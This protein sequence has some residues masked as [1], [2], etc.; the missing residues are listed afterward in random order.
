MPI[1]LHEILVTGASGF[2]GTRLIQLLQA[3]GHR[4][5][6]LDLVPG[7][8]TDIIADV[9]DR[10]ALEAH[11]PEG[12]IVF[13]LAS[14]VG[15]VE[16]LKRPEECYSCSVEGTR[17]LCRSAEKRGAR[18]V[19]T[20][21]SE[22]YGDGAGEL[23]SEDSSLPA[24][25]GPWPRASY[26][27]GKLRAE[28]LVRTFH[29]RGGDGRIARFFNVTGPGQEW[30]KGP[31]LPTFVHHA[32]HGIPL[33]VIGEGGDVRC[34]QHVDD[35][36]AGLMK[37]GLGDGLAGQTINLGGMD[38]VSVE[39]LAHR[40]LSLLNLS[41]TIKNVSATDRYGGPSRPCTHRIPTLER[42]KELLG[43]EPRVP[44]DKIILE[45]AATFRREDETES[46]D[47][48]AEA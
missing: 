43:H 47:R 29:A 13:H 33:P 14:V 35:A 8:Y 4:T 38:S 24:H 18:I 12:G 22:V 15:I 39:Q 44:L 6:G 27:E 34:F 37:L 17:N 11:V 1:P 41:G 23:L 10:K 20:S 16:V 32:L 31:V 26:P 2:V 40:V 30:R 42:A 3:K 9:R 48:F 21:S 7:P 25:H 36:A 45:T 46:G 5:L 28:E 19:F